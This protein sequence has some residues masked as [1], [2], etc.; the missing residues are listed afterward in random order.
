MNNS[1][2][3]ACVSVGLNNVIPGAGNAPPVGPSIPRISGL[4]GP[5]IAGI[6]NIPGLPVFPGAISPGGQLDVIQLVCKF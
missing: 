1:A 3:N 5:P 2:Y 4:G 6:P